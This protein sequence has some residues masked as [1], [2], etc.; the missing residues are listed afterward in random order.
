ML[1]KKVGTDACVCLYFF[2]QVVEKTLPT[3]KVGVVCMCDGKYQV[4]ACGFSCD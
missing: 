1:G 4:S 2:F 3:E